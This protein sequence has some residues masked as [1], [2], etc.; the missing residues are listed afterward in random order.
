[1]KALETITKI[2]I[3]IFRKRGSTYIACKSG[4]ETIN[5]K[6]Y[7]QLD[8]YMDFSTNENKE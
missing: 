3:F 4:R 2:Y 1:M 6:S 7:N 5:D 8:S